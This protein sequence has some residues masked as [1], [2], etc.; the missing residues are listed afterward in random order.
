LGT[1]CKKIFQ[2]KNFF[3]LKYKNH[4]NIEKIKDR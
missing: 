3:F 1:I 2:Q 4:M